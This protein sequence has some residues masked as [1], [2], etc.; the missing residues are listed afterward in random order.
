MEVK[1]SL[2]HAM[3]LVNDVCLAAADYAGLGFKISEGGRLGNGGLQN[4]V[5]LFPDG[6]HLEL[7][8]FRRRWL[9]PGLQLLK[10]VGLLSLILRRRSSIVRRIMLK[11]AAS[12]GL[13]DFF[14]SSGS[15]EDD[16]EQ[17][18]RRGLRLERPLPFSEV[19]SDGQ[20][21]SWLLASPHALDVPVIIEHSM[22]MPGGEHHPNGV[23]GVAGVTVAVTDL[24]ASVA[25]YKQLLG[26]D[27]SEGASALSEARTVDFPF[28]PPT[29]TLA[30]PDGKSDSLRG[31]LARSGEGPYALRLRTAKSGRVGM[32]DPARTHGA[33]LELV[34]E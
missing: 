9:L 27:P 11:A 17:A 33:R 20:E 4:A 32:L 29:I 28:G 8:G 5:V 1:Y 14:V 13:L 24:D 18:R 12:K 6:S 31:H 25:R 15:I 23:E 21:I 7:L 30:T 26:F 19:L 34:P 22:Q 10:R 2:D 16:V 3:I